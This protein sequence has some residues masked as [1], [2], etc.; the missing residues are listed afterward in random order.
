[1]SKPRVYLAGPIKGLNYNEAVEWREAA[2]KALAVLGIDGMSPMRA[3]DY[4]KKE[5]DVSGDKLADQYA[6]HP[7]STMK[8]IVTRDRKDC[9]KSD[10]VIMYL[11]GAKAVSI[12]SVMECAWADAARI[13]LILVMEKNGDNPHRHG[14]VIETAGFWV[15]TLDEAIHIVKAVLLP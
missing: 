1:M 5:L 7:L 8:A 9:M 2:T 12:G 4:L 6:E 3:K 11:R 13:P 14:M 15:E 10:A